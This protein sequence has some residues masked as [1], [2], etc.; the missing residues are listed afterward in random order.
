MTYIDTMG[1]Y[2]NVCMDE[3]L[4]SSN[5]FLFYIIFDKYYYPTCTFYIL[6]LIYESLQNRT[7]MVNAC[8]CS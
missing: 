6:V 2:Q 1:K 8:I 3:I 4:K 5:K 7:L